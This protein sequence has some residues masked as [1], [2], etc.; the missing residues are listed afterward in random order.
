VS[1]IVDK[2][3]YYTYKRKNKKCCVNNILTIDTAKRLRKVE[4]GSQ[5][6]DHTASDSDGEKLSPKSLYRLKRCR[7]I[8][9]RG[10]GISATA[11]A[12][13]SFLVWIF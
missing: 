10:R 1:E 13:S 12:N 8:I 3:V 6:A 9:C 4:E 11:L 7:Y 2:N 5:I